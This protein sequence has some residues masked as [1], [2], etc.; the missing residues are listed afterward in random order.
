MQLRDGLKTGTLNSVLFPLDPL[1]ERPQ[2]FSDLRRVFPPTAYAGVVGPMV[3]LRWRASYLLTLDL[4]LLVE[5]PSPVRV[6]VLGRVQVLLP[7]QS[8]PLIQIRM[9]ALGVLDVSAETV[10]LDATL[11]DSK[12]LQSTPDG[13]HGLARGLGPAAAVRAGHR[14]LPSAVCRATGIARLAAAGLAAGRRRLA[15]VALSGYLAVTSNTVRRPRG[16]HAAGGFS[17]DGLLG[18]GMRSSNWR[19][20]P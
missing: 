20:W 16:P 14:R 4:A 3:Q 1:R 17:F 11:Y 19:P 2:I 6:I 10:A 9:D 18:F 5:L 13:R 8:Y 15:A 12:I 7:N